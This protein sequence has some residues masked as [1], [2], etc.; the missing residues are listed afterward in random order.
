[1]K[2]FALV[3]VAACLFAAGCGGGSDTV[4]PPVL[5]HVL[6]DEAIRQPMIYVGQEWQRTNPQRVTFDFAPT[7]DLLERASGT[8]AVAD[9]LVTDNRADMAR[10]DRQGLLAGDPVAVATNRLVVGIPSIDTTIT[11]LADLRGTHWIRCRPA[12]R[13]GA[14]TDALFTDVGSPGGPYMSTEPLDILPRVTSGRAAAGLMWA[15]E[16]QEAGSAGQIRMVEIPGATS[17]IATY[18]IAPLRSAAHADAAQGLVDL[19]TSARGRTLMERGRFTL[20]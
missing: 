15:S 14:L 4:T 18:Y 17:H 8:G 12:T 10:A 11:G 3:V 20:P 13:C 19:A 5:V 6:A 2:S 7:P 16:A 1:M 9:V